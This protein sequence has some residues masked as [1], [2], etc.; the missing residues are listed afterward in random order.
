MHL[1]QQ[2]QLQLMLMVGLLLHLLDQLVLVDL[3]QHFTQ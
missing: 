2:L 1:T 3:Y